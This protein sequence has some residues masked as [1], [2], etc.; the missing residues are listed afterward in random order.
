MPDG[1]YTTKIGKAN[2]VASGYELTIITYG[3][4]VH[5]CLDA[6]EKLNIS[7]EVVDLR[8]LQPWDKNAVKQ[9]VTKTGKVIV[10]HEDTLEGGIGAEI[11]AWISEHCFRFL[12]APVMRVASLDTPIPFRQDLEEQF[13]GKSRLEEKIVELVKW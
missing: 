6:I 4:A 7:A 2:I 11:A 13:L 9:A 10:V 12:D 8:T 3:W 5:W 1:Y